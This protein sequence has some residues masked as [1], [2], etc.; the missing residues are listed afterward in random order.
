MAVDTPT[1]EDL[2]LLDIEPL[3]ID[4]L[5]NITVALLAKMN[6]LGSSKL[7]TEE[8]VILSLCRTCFEV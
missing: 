3:S 8:K 4:E 7:S 1:C 6:T 2:T 5:S